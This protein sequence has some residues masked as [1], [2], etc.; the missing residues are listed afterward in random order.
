MLTRLLKDVHVDDKA[1]F[2]ETHVRACNL[3][4]KVSNL[5]F[6]VII[7][8]A[9]STLDNYLRTTCEQQ[10]YMKL[11]QCIFFS[12]HFPPFFSSH[13]PIPTLLHPLSPSPL[14]I[15]SLSPLLLSSLSP[16]VS[17]TPS[18]PHDFN[19]WMEILNYMEK[20]LHLENSDMLVSFYSS[21]YS[22]ERQIVK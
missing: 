21:Q 12:C 19:L 18:F 16:G 5:L 2:E 3:L 22:L 1:G 6:K 9:R 14:T 20:F 10:G 8:C 13:P 15:L 4:C 17:P 7:Y 11:L